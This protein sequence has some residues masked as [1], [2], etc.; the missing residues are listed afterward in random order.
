MYLAIKESLDI[1]WQ[2]ILAVF[3]GIAVIYLTILILT[4]I[5]KRKK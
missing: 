2:G 3:L 4:S 5:R 1:A